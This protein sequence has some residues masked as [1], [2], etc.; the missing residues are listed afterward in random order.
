MQQPTPQQETIADLIERV[1]PSPVYPG[2]VHPSHPRR[3]S[4][5]TLLPPRRMKVSECAAKHRYVNNPGGYVGPW[6]NSVAPYMV[7]P[8]DLVPSREFEAIVFVG[9]AQSLKTAG[10]VENAILH[11]IV[12]D[13]MR[14]LVVEKTQSKARDFSRERIAQMNRD[15]PAVAK[16]VSHASS[17]DNIFDKRYRG[18]MLLQMGWP[19]ENTLAGDPIPRVYLTD[20]DRFKGSLG[21][22]GEAFDL[23]MKRGQTFGSR[24]MVIAESSPSKPVIDPRWKVPASTPH[25]APPTDGGILALYNRGDRR[26]LLW[27][28][29]QCNGFYEGDF[30]HLSWPKG[31]PRAEAAEA[32]VMVCPHCGHPTHPSQRNIMLPDAV[33][34]KEGQ[35]INDGGIVSG[36][37]LRATIA[38]FWLKGAAAA[39]QPWP[40][41]VSKYLIAFEDFE[42]TGKEESL[43]VTINVDQSLPYLER[44][45]AD[46]DGVNADD[47]A[48]RAA[49]ENCTLNTVPNGARFITAFVDVQGTWFDVQVQ[50]H[51]IGA[52]TWVVAKYRIHRAP[53]DADRLLDPGR[54]DEDWDLLLDNVVLKTWPLDDATGRVMTVKLTGID[55]QGAP[56]VYGRAQNF[57]MRAKARGLGGRIR[58]TRGEP[59]AREY[60]PRVAETYPDSQRKDKNAG[61]RGEVPVLNL[62][63][64]MLKDDVLTAL[65]L[66]QPGPRFVHFPPGLLSEAGPPHAYFDEV[67]SE[68]RTPKGWKQRLKRNEAWDQL[69]VNRALVVHLKADRPKFWDRPPAWARDWDENTGVVAMPADDGAAQ[70]GGASSPKPLTLADRMAQ[71]NAR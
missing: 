38:S 44:A 53:G 32:V 22:E 59:N 49:E 28:C 58:L 41:L 7:E 42:H 57:W 48:A 4:A 63:P 54:Y 1:Y 21:G 70:T 16:R 39:F 8:M 2:Y 46:Q 27:P 51:G 20:Y 19:T 50:A 69:Y 52:E 66:E 14:T 37:G 60:A 26:R 9:P 62:N 68:I 43:R 33:W 40:S 24:A 13:P 56:G 64:N 5:E 29:P 35:K 23:A 3:K 61:A 15:T 10:L 34:L 6:D 18:N 47:L 65:T 30:H 11:S 12:C 25:M 31:A 71:L 45:L 36:D 67:C 55:S 17:D